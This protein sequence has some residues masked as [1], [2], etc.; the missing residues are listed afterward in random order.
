MLFYIWQTK[1]VGMVQNGKTM[2][3]K[4]KEYANYKDMKRR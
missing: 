1:I 2:E 3:Y 4:A